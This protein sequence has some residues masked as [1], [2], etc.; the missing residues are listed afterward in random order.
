MSGKSTGMLD[1]AIDWHLASWPWISSSNTLELCF[2]FFFWTCTRWKYAVRE[3]WIN[4]WPTKVHRLVDTKSPEGWKIKHMQLQYLM[5]SPYSE[6]ILIKLQ[7]KEK[8]S[9]PSAEDQCPS[10]LFSLQGIWGTEQRPKPSNLTFQPMSDPNSPVLAIIHS[11]RNSLYSERI[12]R[13]SKMIR[14][15]CKSYFKRWSEIKTDYE[16]FMEKTSPSSASNGHNFRFSALY[17]QEN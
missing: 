5:V 8:E 6:E 13:E 3:P 15:Q 14:N 1:I 4:L 12:K 2:K 16:Y 9:V 11:N 17:F 7:I 10:S